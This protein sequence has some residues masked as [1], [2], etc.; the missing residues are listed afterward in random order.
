MSRVQ[1]SL[2][3]VSKQFQ[4]HVITVALSKQSVCAIQTDSYSVGLYLYNEPEGGLGGTNNHNCMLWS[5]SVVSSLHS[6]SLITS[7]IAI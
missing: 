3:R 5:D 4:P 7:S 1:S 2:L 6:T